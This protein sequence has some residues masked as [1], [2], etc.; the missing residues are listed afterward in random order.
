MVFLASQ[1]KADTNLQSNLPFQQERDVPKIITGRNNSTG[2]M[3]AKKGFRDSPGSGMNGNSGAW[4]ERQG[5]APTY[6]RI[7]VYPEFGF[8]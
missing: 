5:N 2:K 8:P 3:K 1:G 7:M 6:E 4:Q